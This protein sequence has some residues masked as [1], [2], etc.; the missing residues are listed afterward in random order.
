MTDDTADYTGSLHPVPG[1]PTPTADTGTARSGSALKWSAARAARETGAARSTVLEA[2][3]AGRLEATKDDAGAWQITPEALGAAGFRPG[4]PTP[5]DPAPVL[6]DRDKADE[7]ERLRAE[8]SDARA[9]SR[10]LTAERDAERYK[11]EAA[12]RERDVYRRMIEAPPQTAPI[13]PQA[14]EQAAPSPTY[15]TTLDAPSND[16]SRVGRFRRAWNVLRY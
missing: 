3:K 4:K 12:E 9:D 10:V 16:A 13:A 14:A 1:T 5:P 11:R 7:L 6:E 8:L 15:K 2:I